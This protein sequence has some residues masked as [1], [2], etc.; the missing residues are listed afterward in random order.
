MKSDNL[1]NLIKSALECEARKYGAPEK[2]PDKLASKI[3]YKENNM[4]KLSVK[5]TVVAAAAAIMLMGAVCYAG[6]KAVN[7]YSSSKSYP[8]Y[9]RYEDL[10]KA[11]SEANVKSYAPESFSN[12][13]V[14]EGINIMTN[15]DCD[16]NGNAVAEYKSLCI[17]YSKDESEISF[18]AEPVIYGDEGEGCIEAYENDGINYYCHELSNKF[19]PVDYVP[20]A[21]E[22][23][24]VAEGTLNIGYGADQITCETSRSVIWTYNG[25]SYHLFAMD[26]ELEVT[27]ADL[28]EMALEIM[29]N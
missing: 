21:E 22:E 5:R 7:Y 10:Q 13:Y 15:K 26:S 19:V 14:F 1:D 9:T 27:C 12:G 28:Y 3:K 18:N 16:G 11:E 23:K 6:G 8:D 17:R 29:A 2:M 20:T 4:R 25:I 24:A